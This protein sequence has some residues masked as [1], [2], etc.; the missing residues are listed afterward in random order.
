MNYCPRRRSACQLVESPRWYTPFLAVTNLS[1]LARSEFIVDVV[2]ERR[3]VS[4]LSVV[5]ASLGTLGAGARRVRVWAA[6]RCRVLDAVIAEHDHP[7]SMTFASL[8]LHPLVQ[9][10]QLIVAVT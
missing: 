7:E 5:D 8:C 3:L 6:P 2:R 9:L 1:R 10:V 4:L